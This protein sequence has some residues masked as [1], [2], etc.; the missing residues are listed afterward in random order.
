LKISSMLA[1]MQLSLETVAKKILTCYG[2]P[3]I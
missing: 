2:R 1:L 3:A